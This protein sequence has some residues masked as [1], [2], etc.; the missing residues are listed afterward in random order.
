MNHSVPCAVL[1]QHKHQ[2]HRFKR[3]IYNYE[4]LDEN[5]FYYLLQRQNWEDIFE[6]RSINESA[7]LFTKI[8]V[9]SAQE[10]MPVKTVSVRS[11]DVAWMTN[12]IRAFTTW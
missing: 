7:H 3:T 8:F 2:I 6:E 9:N 10:C 1:Q 5:K 4:K 12:E 11:D